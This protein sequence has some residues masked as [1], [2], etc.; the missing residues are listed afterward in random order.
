MSGRGTR[1]K[2]KS[3]RSTVPAAA[4]SRVVILSSIS[5]AVLVG[6]RCGFRGLLLSRFRRCR[7]HRQAKF[8]GLGNVVRQLLLHCVAKSDPAAL[9]AGHRTFNQDQ[10]ALDIGLH[11]LQVERGDALDTHMTGH[12]LVLESLARIL[13]AAGRPMRAVR[14][15]NAMRCAQAA[16]IP[17]LH[18]TSKALADRNSG[19][20]DELTNREMISGNLSADR[21]QVALLDAELGQLALG[22]DLRSCEMPALRLGHPAGLAGAG[23]EL[24]RD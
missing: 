11:H 10:A 15:R 19:N 9:V 3:G 20:I 7:T 13:A 21:D 8:A 2:I 6:R 17:A 12:L 18:G 4:P 14:Y 22:L 5:G 16:E 24:Q 1:P 23:A